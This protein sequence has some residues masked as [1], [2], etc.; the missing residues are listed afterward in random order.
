M[1]Y[2]FVDIRQR[3]Y[4]AFLIAL[5]R[6]QP[7]EWSEVEDMP[8]DLYM[9]LLVRAAVDAEWFEE[10]PDVDEL[11]PSEIEPIASAVAE[12]YKEARTPDPN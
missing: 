5:K 3:Q 10:P 8:I 6:F 1:E 11:K 12:I 9:D 7:E 4:R 2:K